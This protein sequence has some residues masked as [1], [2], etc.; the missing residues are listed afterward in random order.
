MH[1]IKIPTSIMLIFTACLLMLSSSP[2]RAAVVAYTPLQ[3]VGLTGA[4][5]IVQINAYGI[6]DLQSAENSGILNASEITVVN[7]TPSNNDPYPDNAVYSAIIV[8]MI[9]PNAKI[10]ICNATPDSCYG[11]DFSN[12]G[13]VVDANADL[14]LGESFSY[15][16]TASDTQNLYHVSD[17]GA[18]PNVLFYLSAGDIYGNNLYA[19]NFFGGKWLPVPTT[20]GGQ[21]VTAWDFGMVTG[22]HSDPEAILYANP[23][24]S[25]VPS[26]NIS[27]QWEDSDSADKPNFEIKAYSFQ[28]G[29]LIADSTNG[30][31]QCTSE[32]SLCIH[33][34]GESYGTYPLAIYVLNNGQ[35]I[36]GE[37]HLKMFFNPDPRTAYAP[38]NRPFYMDYITGGSVTPFIPTAG[39]NAI[40]V[41]SGYI[42]SLYNS[43]L[44]PELAFNTQT[45]QFNEFD[46]PTIA[47]D[48]CLHIPQAPNM[49]RYFCGNAAATSELGGIASLLEQAGLT[50]TQIESG[51][52]ATA[53]DYG[54]QPN[55]GIWNAQNGY[56][57][58]DPLS[59]LKQFV[60]LPISKI[61]G[62]TT[63][64]IE[65]GHSHIFYGSCTVAK[66]YSIKAYKWD[67]GDGTKATG[68]MVTH[69]FGK[70]IVGHLTIKLYCVETEPNGQILTASNPATVSS[71]V[72]QNNDFAQLYSSEDFPKAGASVTYTATCL[73]RPGSALQ[74][75]QLSF[76]DAS[77]PAEGQLSGNQAAETFKLTHIY[78]KANSQGYFYTAV[79]KCYSSQ[80]NTAKAQAVVQVSAGNNG[81]PN[82]GG[83]GG[84]FE[85]YIL[86]MFG[87][88]IAFK[89]TLSWRS[90][91]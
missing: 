11:S 82:S 36:A 48:Q 16:D 87:F 5:T 13:I 64:P 81:T 55:S 34:P 86:L 39:P 54:G 60:S 84:A 66:G 46:Y 43:S 57:Y 70:N 7:P 24:S 6:R 37:A 50:A 89:N 1:S 47:A 15:G 22:N 8:H 51:E 53:V 62:P 14:T 83:G 3:D 32:H 41:K 21:A 52:N 91:T 44:G 68:K 31:P 65:D 56:G 79:L 88:M 42:E 61:L 45:G 33:I 77:T 76:G 35:S 58:V 80:G 19:G 26:T 2:A 59:V 17:F 85:L 69:T 49:N 74:G 27:L 71:Y 40:I 63:V 75:W 23:A 10:I 29:P 73:P 67:F 78:S 20:V 28:T 30:P 25:S 72:F 12:A 18:N 9:A 90:Q 4:D 38:N